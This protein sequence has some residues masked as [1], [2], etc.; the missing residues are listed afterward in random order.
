MRL[1]TV[2]SLLL[3]ALLLAPA[4]AVAQRIHADLETSSDPAFTELTRSFTAA[5]TIYIRV[6]TQNADAVALALAPRGAGDAISLT[7]EV[8]D[9][10]FAARIPASEL[11]RSSH[12]LVIAEVTTGDRTRRLT[13]PIRIGD[14]G[15]GNDRRLVEITGAIEAVSDSS[16][17][18]DGTEILVTDSTRIHANR[19]TPVTLADLVPGLFVQVI[20]T[21]GRDD[22]LIALRIRVREYDPDHVTVSGR[23]EALGP[24]ARTLTVAS[25]VFQVTDDTEIFTRSGESMTY[26]DLQVGMPVRVHGVV[27]DDALVA[28]EIRVHDSISVR[29]RLMAGVT[30][31]DGFS[32]AGVTFIIDDRTRVQNQDALPAP[33]TRVVVG[34]RYS[35]DG[36]LHAEHIRILDQND[37]RDTLIG[38]VLIDGDALFVSGIRVGL[39][40]STQFLNGE[41]Q[42]ITIESRMRVRVLGDFS[43]GVVASVIQARAESDVTGRVTSRL[44]DALTIA[45]A[46]VTLT[47]T[48][49]VLNADGRPVEASEA[50]PGQLLEIVASSGDSGLE[51]E[52]VT[53]LESADFS[54]S[55]EPS[56]ESL[57]ERFTLKGN[58]P[59]PFNPTTTIAFE[60][61]E[62]TDVRLEIF[63]VM[64]RRVAMLASGVLPAGSHQASWNGRAMSGEPVTSGMYLYRLSV[65]DV[66]QTRSMLLLK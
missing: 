42:P 49:S 25:M 53:I 16:I 47:E 18:V 35:P 64:G 15:D 14:R 55:T 45:G 57:P 60:L 56:A 10:R 7:P 28:T 4:E 21:P 33:G 29:G 43:Q 66:A 20:A 63:D 24:D 19:N 41:G 11:T 62:T 17:T 50:Q 44:G 8:A 13:Q 12:W 23:I 27:R 61:A 65:G 34:F 37:A 31:G 3:V 52:I 1:S 39:T 46:V 5:D 40:D 22:V 36:G 9:G 48:T 59:N 6:I 26:A 51:A 32:V 54:T 2:L 30:E 38:T 58:Y